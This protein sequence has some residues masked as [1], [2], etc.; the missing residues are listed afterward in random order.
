MPYVASNGIIPNGAGLWLSEKLMDSLMVRLYILG[1]DIDGFDLVHSEG[2]T[3]VNSLNNDYNLG[4]PELNA[5]F[6][7]GIMGPIK[8]WEIDYPNNTMEDSK[9][10]NKTYPSTDLWMVK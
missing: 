7:A 1:E 6:Q 5:H 4:L 10:L 2:S 3:I 9:Y 8:I